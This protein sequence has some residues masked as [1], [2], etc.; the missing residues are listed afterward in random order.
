MDLQSY[1]RL[2][3]KGWRLVAAVTLL[4]VGVAALLTVLTPKQY[5]STLQFFVS[6]SD[7]TDTSQ[8][9]QGS[10]FT[11]QRVK[12]YQQLLTTPKVLAP[13]ISD[14]HLTTTPAALSHQVSVSV[15]PDTVLINVS[16][17]DPKAE[18]A[19]AIA[20]MIA[21]QFPTTV[22]DIERVSDSAPSPIKVTLVQPASVNDTP[23]AP[24]PT[25]NLALGLILGL[26]LGGALTVLRATLDNRVRD[27]ADIEAITEAPVVG[28]IPFDADAPE[29]PLI[30]Q[31]DPRSNRAEAFRSLRTNLQFL[32]VANHPRVIVV[33]SS[34]AGEG[35]TTTAANL[36]LTLAQSGARVCLIE[37]DLRRP[38]LLDYLGL[39]GAVGITDVLIGRAALRD[40]IQ[41]FGSENLSVIGAGVLPPNPSE[42]LGSTAMR[43]V[44]DQL[45]GLFD[46]VLIDAPPLLPVTDAAI[47]STFTGGAVMIAG[48]GLV[49][50][51]QLDA[52][53]GTLEAVN[54]RV[55]GIVLNRI[56]RSAAGGYYDYGYRSDAQ[57][58]AEDADKPRRR[59]DRV[60]DEG[61]RSKTAADV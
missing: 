29:H 43:D 42:L 22:T 18:Q 36:A 39:E 45:H 24:R 30:V 26:L 49:T 11:Q 54:G 58:A 41:P 48:S 20:Q 15:P 51:D 28:A 61:R 2:L 60:A 8:L 9:A 57:Q 3:R 16:V 1:V 59:R 10:T 25:R 44:V 38:R 53:L 35:K 14:L 37:G 56:P 19:A 27:K 4:V 55:L 7:S 47:L 13:V 40:V 31:A 33:T 34:L 52:A 50:R 5:E 17:R 23:V 6:T 46:Y 32:D 12:S 21:K